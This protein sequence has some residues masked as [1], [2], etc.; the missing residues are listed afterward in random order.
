MQAEHG[1]I[2]VRVDASETGA[3]L[4]TLADELADLMLA[5]RVAVARTA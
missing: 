2:T 3:E 4:E 1:T 5:R